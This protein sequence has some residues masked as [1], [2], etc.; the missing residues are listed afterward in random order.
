MLLDVTGQPAACV[1]TQST[2]RHVSHGRPSVLVVQA[3]RCDWILTHCRQWHLE[4][5]TAVTDA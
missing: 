2:V 1:A 3:V 5:V 4:D